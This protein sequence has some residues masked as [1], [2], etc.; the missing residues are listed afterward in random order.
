[1]DTATWSQ[2]SPQEGS[3]EMRYEGRNRMRV[4]FLGLLALIALAVVIA[5]C[6]GGSSSSSSSSSTTQETTTEKTTPP[7]SGEESTAYTYPAAFTNEELEEPAGKNWIDHGGNNFNQRYSSLNEI[8][9]ENVK[10]L[11]IAWHNQD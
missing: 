2:A 3:R 1:M 4:L 6:G 5:G 9:P 7:G 11:D 10:E 8:T